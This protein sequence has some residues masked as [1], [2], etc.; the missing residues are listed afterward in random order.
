MKR[1]SCGCRLWDTFRTGIDPAEASD[2][3][4]RSAEHTTVL[5]QALVSRAEKGERTQKQLTLEAMEALKGARGAEIYKTFV[6]NGTWHTPTIV[7]ARSFLLRAE[8]AARPDR[9]RNYVAAEVK[10]HWEKHNPVPQNMSEEELA[11][12][13]R[14][15]EAFLEIV[16]IMHR[17]GV[18]MLAGTDP[19]TRDVFP[20]FSLHDEL[21]LLVRAG[22]TPLEAI[23]TATLNA[24]KCLGLAD[25]FGTIEVGKFADLVLLDADPLADI[26]N[27][28]KIDAV[29]SRGKLVLRP[30]LEAL[31][32]GAE[33]AIKKR[34]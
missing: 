31:L 16:G 8:M 25:S 4:Q 22:L 9:R 11:E 21:G 23:Q 20:G 7:V 12:R 32:S 14:S 29:I 3:G 24:A 30:A 33:A 28:Q 13:R 34:E 2:A 27:T 5:L 17:A 18:P 1:R 6:Q 26:S 15:F 10:Q 19:P